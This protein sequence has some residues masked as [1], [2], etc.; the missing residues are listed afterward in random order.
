MSWSA[1]HQASLSSTF[2][3]SLLK[4]MSTEES[5]M[6]SNH[7]FLCYPLLLLLSVLPS[8]RDFSNESVLC[9]RWPKYWGFSF[10]ISPSNEHSGLIS[11]RMDWLDLFAVQ[12][13]V[14]ILLQNP[15]S[16]ASALSF[17]WSN[18]HNSHPNI[19]GLILCRRLSRWY[20]MY[21]VLTVCEETRKVGELTSSSHLPH[22]QSTL[23]LRILLS[24][25][26]QLS[27]LSG[28]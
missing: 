19:S 18:S 8:I 3:Q 1:A 20:F 10:S 7:L 14:S 26:I 4:F 17:I 11:F 22:P 16:K 15:N 13:T 12:W 9:I 5:V 21:P 6:Y 2:S 24:K 27:H 25:L 28:G 23:W